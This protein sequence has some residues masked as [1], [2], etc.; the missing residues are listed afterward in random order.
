MRSDNDFF[1]I[2]REIDPK[3]FPI[4]PSKEVSGT[5]YLYINPGNQRWLWYPILQISENNCLQ[6]PDYISSWDS[7]FAEKHISIRNIEI[8][9]LRIGTKCI[10]GLTPTAG[11]YILLA[12][13]LRRGIKGLRVDKSE[14]LRRSE[15]E[16]KFE[17]GRRIYAP[18]AV[19]RLNCIYLADS[20]VVLQRM[21]KDSFSKDFVFR[22]RIKQ[23]MN[24]SKV[25]VEWYHKYW[26][27]CFASSDDEDYWSMD[28]NECIKN[29]WTSCPYD[30]NV[31]NWEYLIDG[32]V[33]LE[34]PQDM[35]R[36]QAMRKNLKL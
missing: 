36:I 16:L 7:N 32:M 8:E 26:D 13:K 28:K 1:F 18:N 11:D 31:N 24:C 6:S 3:T 27:A 17:E 35:K 21:F 5:F 9:E 20:N 2:Q 22:V 25:D 33:G 10:G 30:E 29:Y 14:I 12:Q 23:R 15:I 34:N 4:D 19:S